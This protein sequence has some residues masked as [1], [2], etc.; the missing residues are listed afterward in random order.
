MPVS[1]WRPVY[2]KYSTYSDWL[3]LKID[4][5]I[6]QPNFITINFIAILLHIFIISILFIAMSSIL[7]GP[8]FKSPKFVSR[9]LV[10]VVLACFGPTPLVSAVPIWTDG[11][12]RWRPV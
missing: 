10:K 6:N 3:Q 5:S 9:Y 2:L 7:T 4:M 12:G 1:S 11:G 8:I